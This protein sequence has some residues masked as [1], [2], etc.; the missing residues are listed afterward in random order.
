MVSFYSRG[1]GLS[2]SDEQSIGCL[3]H[4]WDKSIS[5][6][7]ILNLRLFQEKHIFLHI[8]WTTLCRNFIFCMDL[9]AYGR[10][11]SK[12]QIGISVKYGCHGNQL[13]IIFPFFATLTLCCVMSRLLVQIGEVVN[14]LIV[15]WRNTWHL[16]KVVDK[17]VN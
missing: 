12:Q 15:H 10:H 6:A 7:T 4:F 1:I 2:F 16:S 17:I 5:M 11:L 8:S 3:S 9:H 14:D 13:F